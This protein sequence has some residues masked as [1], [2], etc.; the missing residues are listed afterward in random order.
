LLLNKTNL[1]TLR[2]AFGDTM[3]GW[4]GKIVVVFPTMTDLRGKMVPAI[5]VRIPAPKQ[6]ATGN[7]AAA[8]TAALQPTSAEQISPAPDDDLD[9]PLTLRRSPK[10]VLDRFAQ[11]PAKPAAK[12]S[13]ADEL[14]DDIPW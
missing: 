3:D 2:G 6:A 12:P 14:D 1:R 13:L 7:G 8:T 11:P 9:I 4:I 10:D 5:R